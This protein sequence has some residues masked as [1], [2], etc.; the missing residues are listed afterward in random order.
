MDRDEARRGSLGDWNGFVEEYFTE[1]QA[2]QKLSYIGSIMFGDR[3]EKHAGR[4]STGRH[5]I[6]CFSMPA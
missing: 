3:S 5:A 4:R 6:H 1:E 2:K